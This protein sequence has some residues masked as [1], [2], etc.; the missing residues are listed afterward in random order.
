MKL[1]IF[2]IIII[3]LSHLSP[4][5]YCQTIT[6]KTK[7][8]TL[9]SVIKIIE[10]YDYAFSWENIDLKQMM[11]RLDIKNAPVDKALFQCFRNLPIS[12]TI[13]GKNIFLRKKA[14]SFTDMLRQLSDRVFPAADVNGKVLDENNQP[15]AGAT[16]AVQKTSKIRATD[17]KGNFFFPKLK[18]SDVLEISYIGYKTIHITIG[19]GIKDIQLKLSPGSLEEVQVIGYGQTTKRLNTGSV[20]TITSAE[21]EKQPISNFLSGLSGRLPGV[22][23]QT[24][25]GLPGGNINIQIRGK[26]SL[27]AG[28]DPLFVVD[29]VPYD[30][31]YINSET[32]LSTGT[33]IGK[34]SPL[35]SINPDD[36][37]SINILKDAGS[38]SIYG[39]RGANGVVLITTK[40]GK[41]ST[42]LT[43]FKISQG[44]S[45]AARLPSLL[46]LDQQLELRKEAFTNSNLS[47]T[48]QVNTTGYAPDLTIWDQHQSTDWVKYMLGGTAFQTDVQ[49]ATSGGSERTT[50]RLSG[51]FHQESSILRG[52]NIYKRGGM[53]INLSH[54]SK[55]SKFSLSLQSTIGKDNNKSSNPVN[56][57][58]N[59]IFLPPN[60]PIYNADGS[61]NW[62]I[63]N[64][65]ADLQGSSR[66][67]THNIIT[68]LTMTYKILP[69]LE[70]NT[71]M[72]YHKLNIDQTQL[73]PV[74]ALYPGRKNYS[75]Y[76][77]NINSSYIIEPHLQYHKQLKNHDIT[78]LIGGT[79]QR[80]SAEG[81][82]VKAS[83]FMN[84]GLME[85]LAAAGSID[86]KSNT[87]SDYKFVSLYSR[88]NYNLSGKYIFNIN[89]RRDGSSK[90]G[91]AN[92]FGNFGSLGLAWIF[93]Q[94]K[95]AKKYLPWISS[96]K[97]RA[98]YG[99]VGNDQIPDYMYLTSY[100]SSGLT[101]QDSPT[102]APAR[103]ANV[104]FKWENTRKL[105]IAGEFGFM[106]D[107]VLFNI[108]FYRNRSSDQ[109][110]N[111]TLPTMTGFSSYQA[112]LPAVVENKGW[113]LELMSQN[114]IGKTFNWSSSFNLT[115]PRNKL[116]S[117]RNF[118]TSSYAQVFQIGYD[119]S[120]ITGYKFLGLNPATGVPE[121]AGNDG[122]ISDTPDY[123]NT[124]GKMSP[125]LYGGFNNTFSYK[126]LSI[127]IFCQYAKQMALGGMSSLPGSIFNNYLLVEDRWR[128]PGDNTL[129]PKA[130][131][132]PDRYYLSSTA[133]YFDASYI[134]LK[135]IA[136]SWQLPLSWNK[137]T[138]LKRTTLGLQAQNIFT[139]WHKDNPLFD[140]ESGVL[141]SFQ[142]NVPPLKTYSLNLQISL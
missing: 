69:E 1:S 43:D 122:K 142:K 61:Y 136:F 9:D 54:H 71:S 3:I 135:N 125:D 97:F 45:Q 38:G 103:I 58:G 5:S 77:R 4:T 14:E 129:I 108:N 30:N 100:S 17:A 90:F 53:M 141:N 55:D 25:N 79:S 78:L 86:A 48:D 37:E 83:N 8:A 52:N 95:W 115:I 99:I 47:P 68:N 120:R 121:F 81:D 11:P 49:A 28:T 41:Q 116:I 111:Y 87:H 63:S 26:G 133:N 91:P 31:S 70:L 131:V 140:P 124:L 39:S 36:I 92:Q 2:I 109:L 134:R 67:Q 6:I 65:A 94:E 73:F 10:T 32:F 130:L 106:N 104:N 12:Y 89:L 24:T 88:I 75:Q 117:F 62:T 102:I 127:S 44:F 40:K 137:K 72:G 114:I 7:H 20:S 128:N 82:L 110:V 35:N 27:T 84:E 34:V 22:F 76:G 132:L 21:L 59:S 66:I 46:T 74:A 29:G 19:N 93:S 98:S 139:L 105:D 18:Q 123:Y 80:K 85:S 107:R 101:Y 13:A 57:I 138:G 60:Y 15:L 51:N 50:F 119:I 23:V 33:I 16:V 96:G 118:E 56:Y 113:E 64:P 126:N 42:D 112:N